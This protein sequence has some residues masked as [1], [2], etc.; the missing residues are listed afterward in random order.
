MYPGRLDATLMRME[1]EVA[2][3]TGVPV[4]E[5]VP[6]P[7][8]TVEPVAMPN[9]QNVADEDQRGAEPVAVPSEV[10][11]VSGSGTEVPNQQKTE[12]SAPRTVNETEVPNTSGSAPREGAAADETTLPPHSVRI[13]TME[14]RLRAKAAKREQVEMMLACVMTYA[15]DKRDALVGSGVVS[16]DSDV[17]GITNDEVEEK[18]GVSDTSSAKY[19]KELVARGFLTKHGKG[20]GV[21][22]TLTTQ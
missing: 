11:N 8:I 15:A 7:S 10:P 16:S 22:Y 19:L 3:Q 20:R 6:A 21:R 5:H 13:Y 12:G 17:V 14:D 18:L 4:P 2:N 9:V 1:P